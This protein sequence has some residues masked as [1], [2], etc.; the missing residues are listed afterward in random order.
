MTCDA[1]LH[2]IRKHVEVLTTS[3]EWQLTQ[4]PLFVRTQYHVSVASCSERFS[5][6]TA[7]VDNSSPTADISQLR[8]VLL[9]KFYQSSFPAHSLI[10]QWEVDATTEMFSA[11]RRLFRSNARWRTYG[12]RRSHDHQLNWPPSSCT[13]YDESPICRCHARYDASRL[14]QLRVQPPPAC[15]RNWSPYS[16]YPGGC[17]ELWSRRH[18]CELCRL[19]VVACGRGGAERALVYDYGCSGRST[20][21]STD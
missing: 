18:D 6:I 10:G 20:S 9:G 19:G 1:I 16:E 12:Q 15:C 3:K 4:A 2:V 21:H 8:I 14:Q 7:R 11:R 17:G 13:N 5:Q